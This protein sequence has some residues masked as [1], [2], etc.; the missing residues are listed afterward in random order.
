MKCDD[1]YK[2]HHVM[3][4]ELRLLGSGEEICVI[5]CGCFLSTRSPQIL[6]HS[7]RAQR[8]HL[9]P[10]NIELDSVLPTFQTTLATLFTKST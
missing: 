9:G 4:D 3:T 2:R 6:L 7:R 10:Q 5:S 1:A 8:L